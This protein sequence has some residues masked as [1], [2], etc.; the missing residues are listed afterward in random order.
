MRAAKYPATKSLD[1]TAMPSLNKTLTM[2]LARCEFIERRE[3]GIALGPSGTGRT[4]FVLG[5]GLAACQKGHKVCFTTAAA[6]VHELIEAAGHEW[7]LIE[8]LVAVLERGSGKPL[9]HLG[10][11]SRFVD[12]HIIQSNSKAKQP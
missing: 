5:L 10:Q 12:L 1:F 4:H 7:M 8:S 9:R 6:P 11:P 2:E 3:N